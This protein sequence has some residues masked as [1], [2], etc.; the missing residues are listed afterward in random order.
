V[1]LWGAGHP[2]LELSLQE[3]EH[4]H[5][6]AWEDFARTELENFLRILAEEEAECITQIEKRYNARR[7]KLEEALAALVPA[8]KKK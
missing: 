3:A 8:G 7:A 2:E 6:V 1:L 4:A 5:D